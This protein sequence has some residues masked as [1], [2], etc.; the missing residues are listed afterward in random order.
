MFGNWSDCLALR[1][2]PRSC[3]CGV[4]LTQ[5]DLHQA[6]G[7]LNQVM[8]L[9]DPSQRVNADDAKELFET[10]G[11]MDRGDVHL[12][13]QS[14]NPLPPW[15]VGA[16]QSHEDEQDMLLDGTKGL[17]EEQEIIALCQHLL[18]PAGTKEQVCSYHGRAQ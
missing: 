17:V 3:E 13:H 12:S 11:K 15:I 2:K 9:V 16:V 5:M 1:P 10:W 7:L 14:I 6:E 4:N 8:E 18:L